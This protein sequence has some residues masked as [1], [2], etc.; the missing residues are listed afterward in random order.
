MTWLKKESTLL[1]RCGCS[2]FFGLL[3]VLVVLNRIFK[4]LLNLLFMNLFLLGNK[5]LLLLVP[6]SRRHTHYTA[7]ENDCFVKLIMKLFHADMLL[8]LAAKMR[9]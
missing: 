8:D 5:K 3:L 6:L 9:L 1:V 2:F 7:I 4:C